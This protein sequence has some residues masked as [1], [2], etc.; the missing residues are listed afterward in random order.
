M[1]LD[2]A[3]FKSVSTMEKEFPGYRFQREPV[4]GEC[5]VIDPKA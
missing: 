5:E 1:G 2:I 3:V 4:T